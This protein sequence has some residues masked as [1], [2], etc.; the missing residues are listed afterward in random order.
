M[1]HMKRIYHRDALQCIFDTDQA[2]DIL[3]EYKEYMIEDDSKNKVSDDLLSSR[4]KEL[5]QK[6]FAIDSLEEW[7]VDKAFEAPVVK[8]IEKYIYR[9][10]YYAALYAEDTEEH[11][12]FCIMRDMADVLIGYFL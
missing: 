10:N 11:Q 9:M 12:Q 8:N 1:T 6:K 2:L 5:S 4:R 7:I 3:D